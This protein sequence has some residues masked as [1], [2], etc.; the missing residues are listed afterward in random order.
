MTPANDYDNT[1]YAY[2]FPMLFLLQDY[3]QKSGKI[4]G[5]CRAQ[6]S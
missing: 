6:L 3:S 5:E 2:L 4:F 1:I